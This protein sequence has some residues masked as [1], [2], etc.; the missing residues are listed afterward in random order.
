MAL[1]DIYSIDTAQMSSDLLPSSKR[2]TENKSLIKSLLSAF[3]RLHNAFYYYLYGAEPAGLWGGGPYNKYDI[4]YTVDGNVWESLE[5]SNTD[6][7]GKSTKWKKILPLFW[8]VNEGQNFSGNR[9]ELEYA[10]NKILGGT[11]VDPPFTSDIYIDPEIAETPTFLVG[12]EEPESSAVGSEGSTEW[13]TAEGT[14]YSAVRFTIMVPT[15]LYTTLG[16]TA[17]EREKCVRQFA[18]RYVLNGIEYAV[19]DY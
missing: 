6:E 17:D 4:V 19:N 11:Y 8:G 7:P 13:I 12:E 10:L 15:A 5:D 2:T 3:S 14:D 18:D 16:S 1:K 9:L